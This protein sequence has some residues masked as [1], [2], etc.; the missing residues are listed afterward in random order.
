MLLAPAVPDV[1][2]LV[3]Q[4]DLDLPAGREPVRTAILRLTAPWSLL[5]VPV[6]VLPHRVSGLS[7]GTQLITRWGGDAGLLALAASLEDPS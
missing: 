5:G 2:P 4:D 7:V 1:A 3:D 6:V